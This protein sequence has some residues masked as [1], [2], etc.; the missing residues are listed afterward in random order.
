MA[1]IVIIPARLGSTRLASKV[2]LDI[3]GKPLIQHVYECATQSRATNVVI[4]TDSEQVAVIAKGFGAEVCLT[5]A[6]H[7]TG[8][9]RITEVADRLKLHDEQVVVNLQGDEPLMPPIVINQVAQNLLDRVGLA[10][11]TV[12]A[13]IEHQAELVD[14]HAVKVVTDKD[15]YALY[16]S[17]ASIPWDRDSFIPGDAMSPT[18]LH[19]RHIGLYAYRVGFLRKFINWP[20][21]PIEAMES[22]EQ[23]RALW[24]GEK[25]HVAEAFERPGPGVDTEGDLEQVRRLLINHS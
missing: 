16:F 3:H 11:A 22:L 17:R 18:H 12:A 23:L 2:L 19:F 20:Q 6:D 13:R 9:D 25:I 15:G 21:S 4:A 14:P 24:Y 7:K 5:R 8:T 10:M 1:F